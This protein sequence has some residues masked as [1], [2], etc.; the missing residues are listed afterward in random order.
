MLV[1]LIDRNDKQ[2][3]TVELDDMKRKPG[4]NY[5]RRMVALK[6]VK[7]IEPEAAALEFIPADEWHEVVSA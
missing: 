7:F 3:T 4:D 1:R 6:G 2:V 5:T